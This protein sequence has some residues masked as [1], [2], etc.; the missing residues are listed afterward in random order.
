MVGIVNFTPLSNEAAAQLLT[1]LLLAEAARIQTEQAK[2]VSARS[3]PECDCG[4]SGPC[5]F[6]RCRA[7]IL[8][9]QNGGCD[10]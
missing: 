5:M 6:E 2:A 9:S 4:L 3:V 8:S 10:G 7:P 1:S